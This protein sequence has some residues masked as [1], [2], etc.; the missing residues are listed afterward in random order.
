MKILLGLFLSFVFVVS[1]FA[2]SKTDAKLLEDLQTAKNNVFYCYEEYYKN[3]NEKNR[4]EKIKTLNKCRELKSLKIGEIYSEIAKRP[5]A[6]KAMLG[7]EIS[8]N[9]KTNPALETDLNKTEFRLE[10][11]NKNINSLLEVQRII[12]IQNQRIIELLEKLTKPD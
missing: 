11:I 7:W 10:T 4:T 8:E 6:I 3:I 9:Y 5:S 1:C 2:Q 12:A